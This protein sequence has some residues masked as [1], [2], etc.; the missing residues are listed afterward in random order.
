[1]MRPMDSAQLQA[2]RREAVA[3]FEAVAE[4]YIA[5]YGIAEVEYHKG[6]PLR[7]SVVGEAQDQGATADDPEA[8]A[9]RASRDR[10]RGARPRQAIGAPA[11]A[12]AR[13]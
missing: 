1:M 13:S 6:G 7:S 12:R 9:Y 2:A 10:A 8:V 4:K 3:R 5:Q 11:R